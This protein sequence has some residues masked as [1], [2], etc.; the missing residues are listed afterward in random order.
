MGEGK[1][2]V[3]E[4]RVHRGGTATDFERKERDGSKRGGPKGNRKR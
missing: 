1:G 3:K 4:W 2:K